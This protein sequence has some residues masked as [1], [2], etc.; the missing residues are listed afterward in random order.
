VLELLGFHADRFSFKT[1]G[2]DG[3]LI[4]INPAKPVKALMA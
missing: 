3:K 1:Q 4:G 2:L